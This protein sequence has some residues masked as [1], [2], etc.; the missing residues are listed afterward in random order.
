MIKVIQLPENAQFIHMLFDNVLLTEKHII[1]CVTL[2][3]LWQ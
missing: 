3:F 2:K 1:I